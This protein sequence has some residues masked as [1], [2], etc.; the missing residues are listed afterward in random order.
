VQAS[1]HRE[2]GRA[3]FTV[4]HHHELLKEISIDSQVWMSHA[5][6]IISVPDSFEVTASTSSVKVAAFK[7]RSE[8][9]TASNSTRK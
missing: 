9:I 7:V 4:D 5:D 1:Q 2:Y 6:T 3:A 8:K